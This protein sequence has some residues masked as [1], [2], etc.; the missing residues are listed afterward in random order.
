MVKLGMTI[1]LGERERER[2]EALAER[3][4]CSRGEVVRRLLHT[5]VS[6]EEA[7]AE[8]SSLALL[9]EA[10]RRAAEGD[11]VWGSFLDKLLAGYRAKNAKT[12]QRGRELLTPTDQCAPVRGL[13][14]PTAVSLRGGL[15]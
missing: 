14:V 8:T 7:L 13:D 11:L 15:P 1:K 9:G 10:A 3:W 6:P 2:L 4:H 5:K 12:G